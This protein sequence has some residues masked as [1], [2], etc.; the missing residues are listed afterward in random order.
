MDENGIVDKLKAWLGDAGIKHFREIKEKHGT[1]L[2]SW[3]DGGI[4]HVVHFRE[5]M[6]VRNKLREI[7]NYADK[8]EDHWYDDNWAELIDLCLE[9]NNESVRQSGS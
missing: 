7:M 5:G 4:P 1:V 8:Y 9:S 2:A 6:M 3:M